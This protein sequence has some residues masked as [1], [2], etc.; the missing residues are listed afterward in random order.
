LVISLP[1]RLARAL[2][3]YSGNG[4]REAGRADRLPTVIG[5]PLA[6]PQ[7]HIRRIRA[8]KKTQQQVSHARRRF[9]RDTGI[10]GG[11]AALAAS[12]PAVALAET[13]DEAEKA[14]AKQGYRLTDHILAYYKSAAS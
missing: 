14:D 3:T 6:A 11:V 5:K 7:V 13:A 12:A 4:Q 2:R 1:Q 8:M 10:S 9:I